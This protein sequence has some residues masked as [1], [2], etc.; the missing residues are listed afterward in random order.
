MEEFLIFVNVS[1]M[2]NAYAILYALK[3]MLLESSKVEE[4]DRL[5]RLI[6]VDDI[7][8]H[9]RYVDFKVF[10]DEEIKRFNSLLS[11]LDEQVAR[12]LLIHQLTGN[13]INETLSLKKNCLV[14]RNG[15]TMFYVYQHKTGRSAFK[16]V[17]KE[18]IALIRRSIEYTQAKCGPTEYV[19]PKTGH[20]EFPM[21]YSTFQYRLSKA[22]NEAQ[23]TDDHGRLFGVDT[24]M[25]RHSYAKRLTEL[26]I[27]DE[28]IAKLLGHANTSS[29]KYYRKFADAKLAEE[30]KEIRGRMS[31]ML[32]ELSKGW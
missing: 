22:L 31:D 20:P 11:V 13:R 17:T 29:L 12:I 1:G 32:D 8:M 27:P 25:F 28:T 7:S 5:S 10:S 19:F 23:L 6:I 18:V 4:C 26:H 9:R 14:E 3:G 16:P 21:S 2:K 30:T 15:K 24:H